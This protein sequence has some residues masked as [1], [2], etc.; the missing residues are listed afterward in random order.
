[1]AEL[2]NSH[3]IARI[4]FILDFCRQK[5]YDRFV[6]DIDKT[7][8]SS[9]GTPLTVGDTCAQDMTLTKVKDNTKVIFRDYL[10]DASRSLVIVLMRHFA[11]LPW[12]DHVTAIKKCK[13]IKQ[14]YVS[15]YIKLESE[16]HL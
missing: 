2:A 12:R 10:K 8:T 6:V 16:F 11:W 7:L 4:L 14:T 3:Y 9:S 15:T 5:E 13:V 1:M